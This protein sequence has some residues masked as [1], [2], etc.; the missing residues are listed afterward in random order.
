MTVEMTVKEFAERFEAGEFEARDVET[1]CRAGWFDW[2]CKD[3]S[4]ANRLKPL[5]TFVK[6]IVDSPK[7][8]EHE[9][10]VFFK[11]NCPCVGRLYDSLSI[12]DMEKGTVLYWV[13]FNDERQTE[14]TTEIV[15]IFPNESDIDE[16][17]K[18]VYVGDKRGAVKW[19][20]NS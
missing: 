17:V 14:G 1:Q 2:F 6:K 5:G 18:T 8:N 9:T 19:F 4:L 20:F 7:F 10:Y 11:N 16:R 13:G 12:C 3:S 15:E